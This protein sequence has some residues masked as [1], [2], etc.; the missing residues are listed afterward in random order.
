[1]TGF[2]P[3]TMATVAT[4]FAFAPSI[5]G[6]LLLLRSVGC[7]S[8]TYWLWNTGVRKSVRGTYQASIPHLS[9]FL[10]PS[11]PLSLLSFLPPSLLS[12]LPP[13]IPPSIPLS[14][15]GLL[16]LEE[17]SVWGY[18]GDSKEQA[19]VHLENSSDKHHGCH[20]N[21]N[22]LSAIQCRLCVCVPLPLYTLCWANG[23]RERDSVWG[24]GKTEIKW[25][26]VTYI[27][28]SRCQTV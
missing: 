20:S 14:L 6:V 13:S 12:F 4:A 16:S 9:L 24:D 23:R 15:P 11:I 21:R 8:T 19:S 22:P 25:E 5:C 18:C 26:R 2:S 28:E 27:V 7:H 3:Y 17:T 10:S 1:M